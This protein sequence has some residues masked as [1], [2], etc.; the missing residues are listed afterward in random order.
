MAESIR[1][2]ITAAVALVQISVCVEKVDLLYNPA[3]GGKMSIRI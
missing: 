3:S 1:A 2:L